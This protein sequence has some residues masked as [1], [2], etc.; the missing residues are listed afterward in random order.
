VPDPAVTGWRR[1]RNHHRSRC[2]WAG[3]VIPGAAAV[4]EICAGRYRHGRRGRCTFDISM[5]GLSG[6]AYPIR[7]AVPAAPNKDRPSRW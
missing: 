4:K 1:Y 5:A 2:S 3:S 7:P 6:A